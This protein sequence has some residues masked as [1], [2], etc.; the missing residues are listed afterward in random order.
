MAGVVVIS[1]LP[2]PIHGSTVMTRTFLRTLD[3]IGIQWHLVDRRFSSS[4]DQVGKFTF[5]KLLSAMWMPFRLFQAVL[6]T[7]A[8]IAVFFVTN[9]S[10]SFL[11]DCA[12]AEVLRLVVRERVLY[13]HTV[14]FRSL[15]E[16]GSLWR[17]LVGRLL[18][19]ATKVV[20][21]GPS[22]AHDVTPW[23][24]QERI[25]F[26]PNAIADDEPLP[27]APAEV[28]N[29]RTILYFSNLI[30]EKGADIFVDLSIKL[31]KEFPDVEFVIAGATVNRA[32]TKTLQR[33][34]AAA[35]LDGR[36]HFTGKVTNAG[37]KWDLLQR[38]SVL[39]FPSTYPFEA[40]P[41]SIIEAFRAGTPV[42]AYDVGGIR[43]LVRDGVTGFTTRPGDREA[44]TAH[45][46]RLLHDPAENASISHSARQAFV[47]QYAQP[48]YQRRWEDVLHGN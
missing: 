28:R 2:P 19:S 1:Q 43:D 11:V 12:L 27:D 46:R 13:V 26:I 45:V 42:V 21:L 9:R 35:A 30:P 40:Q 17:R 10:F 15:A 7:R 25:V 41:L 39:V 32:F 8:K 48:Q 6:C 37:E 3:N 47:S 38:A 29:H 23:V 34:V 18:T 5:G 20:C 44:L 31:A 14:G 16:R 4:I 22:L 36:V 24:A 33:K